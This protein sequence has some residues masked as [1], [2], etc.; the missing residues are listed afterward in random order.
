M[1]QTQQ[2]TICLVAA[3]FRITGICYFWQF[4]IFDGDMSGTVYTD[5][6]DFSS[7]NTATPTFS[8]HKLTCFE[9]ADGVN[10][11]TG[12][13]ISDLAMYYSSYLMHLTVRLVETLIRSIQQ[14]H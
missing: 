5:S 4:S 13:T 3:I 9:Y 8:H 6:L 7:A 11:P 1:Y 12:F 2:T 14:I 10:I